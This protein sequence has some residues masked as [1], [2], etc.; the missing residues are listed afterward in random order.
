MD[1][2]NLSKL[3]VSQLRGLCKEKGLSNYWKI[4]KA[5]L[6]AKLEGAG[7][8]SDINGTSSTSSKPAKESQGGI[9]TTAGCISKF[10]LSFTFKFNRLIGN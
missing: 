5:A 9:G 1:M 6:L 2:A 3:T 8:V 4:S 10:V 7:V